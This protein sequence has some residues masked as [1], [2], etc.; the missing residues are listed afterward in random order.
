MKFYFSTGGKN[1][2]VPAAIFLKLVK[3]FALA[4]SM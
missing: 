1:N 4:T 3:P 2:F